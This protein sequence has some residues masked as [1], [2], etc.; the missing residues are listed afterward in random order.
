MGTRFEGVVVRASEEAV[1]SLPDHLSL[2][3]PG[4]H[5]RIRVTFLA[6]EVPGRRDAWW[7]EFGGVNKN[8]LL[9]AVSLPEEKGALTL[10][11]E[12]ADRV[13]RSAAFTACK[14]IAK[15][16]GSATF[17][18]HSDSLCGSVSVRMSASG[19]EVHSSEAPLARADEAAVQAL[20]DFFPLEYAEDL[21]DLLEGG[22]ALAWR[23]MDGGAVL[24]PPMELP[25][26]EPAG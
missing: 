15:A 13:A 14:V 3:V 8:P 21:P 11:P 2:W 10:S 16:L 7:L 9:S 5:P 26:E 1:R 24:V 20:R 17:V 6:T 4:V 19:T 23:L 12:W 18:L 22:R 25:G